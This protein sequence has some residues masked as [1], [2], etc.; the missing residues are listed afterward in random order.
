MEKEIKPSEMIGFDFPTAIKKVIDG[1]KIRRTSWPVGEYGLLKDG[2]LMIIKDGE[3][4]WLVNDGDM[5][6][7]DWVVV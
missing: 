2:F 4:R 6:G 7:T 3:H 1:N 5:T